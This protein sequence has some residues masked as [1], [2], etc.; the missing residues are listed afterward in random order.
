MHSGLISLSSSCPQD[1]LA[2][3]CV[4]ETSVMNDVHLFSAA[5]W[6]KSL[7]PGTGLKGR[8][9][10]LADVGTALSRS[11][12]WPGCPS[13]V[14]EGRRGVWAGESSPSAATGPVSE[15]ACR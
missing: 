15:Q 1:L 11:E 9:L 4:E 5:W 6:L 3:C 12:H 14:P 7:G 2:D 10:L 8:T 13:L